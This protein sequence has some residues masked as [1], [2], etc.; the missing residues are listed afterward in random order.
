MKKDRTGLPSDVQNQTRALEA[1]PDD[2]IDTTDIPEVSDWSGAG[3]GVFHRPL[4]Q[5]ITLRLDADIIAWFKAHARGGGG[6]QTDINGVLRE[7]VQ[8]VDRS[9]RSPASLGRTN[10]DGAQAIPFRELWERVE[11]VKPLIERERGSPISNMEWQAYRR[12]LERMMNI[13]VEALHSP[14]LDMCREYLAAAKADARAAEVLYNRKGQAALTLYHIQQGIEKA[15]KALC[16][17][18]GVATPQTLKHHRTPQ[19]LLA[20]LGEDFLGEGAKEFLRALDKGYREKLK[21]ANA[22]VNNRQDVLARLPFRR[23]GWDVGIED[24]L[25]TLDNLARHQEWFERKEDNVKRILAGCLPEYEAQILAFAE[26]KYGLAASKCLV[27]GA[28]TYPHESSTRYPGGLLEPHDYEGDL[29]IV[30][31]IP[32]LLER[33]P[34][35][36]QSVEELVDH[37]ESKG[38][39]SE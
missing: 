5:Q 28:I 12:A 38:Q 11:G 1:L 25:D 36:I 13:R 26:A 22:L 8:K 21:R 18:I 24:L 16:L 14:S 10:V 37:I 23:T 15:T 39:T 34:L 27:L 29:G 2:Q 17:A 3:R 30:Q 19:P 9:A 20:A 4:K 7:H 33:M 31:A 35:T 32:S 6:Y